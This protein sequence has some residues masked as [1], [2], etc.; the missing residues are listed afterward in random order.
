MMLGCMA[1]ELRYFF[2]VFF[3]FFSLYTVYFLPEILLYIK[4]TTK[5]RIL[6][7]GK[8]GTQSTFLSSSTEFGWHW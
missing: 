5:D 1:N 6:Q 2:L 7:T 4:P 3:L 8:N